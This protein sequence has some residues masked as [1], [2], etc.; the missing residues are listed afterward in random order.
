MT[1]PAPPR[2]VNTVLPELTASVGLTTRQQLEQTH[3]KEECIQCHDSIDGV[4][5]GFESFDAIGK[6]RT[7]EFDM[8]VDDSGELRGTDVDGVFEGAVEL[9]QKLADSEQVRECVSMQALRY[10]L[11]AERKEVSRCMVD[12]VK[13]EFIASGEDMRELFIAVVKSDAFRYR[14]AE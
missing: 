14:K 13:R 9:G 8:P 10:A 11:A 5:F 6:H 1:P 7:T 3:V 12:A 4:G 2:G